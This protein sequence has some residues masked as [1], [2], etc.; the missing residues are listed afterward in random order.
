MLDGRRYVLPI[1]YNMPV[2]LANLKVISVGEN[3]CLEELVWY[4]TLYQPLQTVTPATIRATGKKPMRH[5]TW[6][7]PPEPQNCG[8]WKKGEDSV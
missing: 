2:L 6:E 1:R 8:F 3:A 5:F 7:L 4:F